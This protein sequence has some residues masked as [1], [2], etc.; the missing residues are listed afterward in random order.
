MS[1]NRI[2]ETEDPENEEELG[3]TFYFAEALKVNK[4]LQKLRFKNNGI[5]PIGCK[6]LCDMLKIN[7]TL[8]TLVLWQNEIGNQG[9]W[10]LADA[11]KVNTGLM[12]LNVKKNGI[13]V[14]AEES[15]CT[16]AQDR[17]GFELKVD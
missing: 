5:R 17:D 2:D 9:A 7:N 1:W 15:L 6:H 10:M 11:L 8:K 16:V 14:D 12:V 3:G 4:T 13:E